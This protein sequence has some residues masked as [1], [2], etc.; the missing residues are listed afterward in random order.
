VDRHVTWIGTV[1]GVGARREEAS[2]G[3]V[4]GLIWPRDLGFS[5]LSER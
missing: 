3:I 5:S 1:P 2:A 4:R